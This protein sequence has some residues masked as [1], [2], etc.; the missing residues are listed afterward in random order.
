M[1]CFLKYSLPTSQPSRCGGLWWWEQ[2]EGEE[3]TRA[4]VGARARTPCPIPCRQ[5]SGN[6]VQGSGPPGLQSSQAEA[7]D[8]RAGSGLGRQTAQGA[9]LSPSLGPHGVKVTG[10]QHGFLWC[11][12]GGG[13][14]ARTQ[15]GCPCE[16]GFT[17]FT[18]EA[19]A[20]SRT[21]SLTPPLSVAASPELGGA[22]A[23]ER[24]S[25]PYLKLWFPRHVPSRGGRSLLLLPEGAL[26]GYRP[27]CTCPPELHPHTGSGVGQR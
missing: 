23:G 4:G 5:R 14:G 25:V 27:T 3:G 12:A 22:G 26:L 21:P 7:G 18:A 13:A 9:E 8:V 1:K 6:T 24:P 10:N 11:P 15:M 17:G 16:L 20:L 19:G 2:Q